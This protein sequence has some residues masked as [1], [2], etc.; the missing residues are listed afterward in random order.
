MRVVRIASTVAVSALLVGALS[1]CGSSAK[2]S[3]DIVP[4]TPGA[5][6]A[7]G[8]LGDKAELLSA[9]AVMQKAGSAKVSISSDDPSSGT[10][11]GLD[12]WQGKPELELT[13]TE[14]GQPMKIRV[15]D[16]V[17]YVGVNDQKAAAFGGRHWLKLDNSGPLGGMNSGFQALAVMIDPAVQLT[18]AAQ[19][20]KLSKIGA[21]SLG[22]VSTQ[23]YQSVMPTATLV[24]AVP[25]LTDAQRKA[26]QDALSQDGSTVTTDFWLNAQHQLVQ[27]KEVGSG[28]ASA[29]PSTGKPNTATTK[30]SDLGVKVTVTAPPAGD[31]IPSSDA[32]KAMGLN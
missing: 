7:G 31:Q 26:V 1:A 8:S 13:M 30:Y 16:G 14:S 23:H 24:A 9:A 21:E 20:G 4:S 17:S 15:L 27:Q 32:L 6:A 2:K 25:N 29:S 22:G 28:G 10:G 5:P 19:N 11:D 12:S 3:A 18:A